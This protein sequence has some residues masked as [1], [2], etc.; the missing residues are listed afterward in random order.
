MIWPPWPQGLGE[1]CGV[2][3]CC[4]P[5]ATTVQTGIH[6]SPLS[7]CQ[8]ELE[9]G[10]YHPPFDSTLYTACIE[11]HLQLQSNHFLTQSSSQP[12]NRKIFCAKGTHKLV[13]GFN[14]RWL[15]YILHQLQMYSKTNIHLLYHHLCIVGHHY[16]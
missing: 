11:I 6:L 16:F 2:S 10:K 13:C 15:C 3:C 9:T 7:C 5:A 14:T 12:A 1:P 8:A 4:P